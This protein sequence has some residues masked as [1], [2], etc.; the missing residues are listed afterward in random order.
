MLIYSI[1]N[2]TLDKEQI[3]IFR[4]SLATYDCRMLT[5]YTTTLCKNQDLAAIS[6]FFVF[7][8]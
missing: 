1:V 8:F 3:D 5:T 2:E 6:V 4:I 7:C